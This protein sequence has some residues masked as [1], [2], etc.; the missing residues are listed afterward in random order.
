MIDTRLYTFL[1]LC[2][3]MNYRITAQA[4]HLTQP[5]VT[6]HI[7]GLEKEL[8]C[9]LFI[10]EKKKLMKTKKGELL[11]EYARYAVK[12]ELNLK[13]R[14]KACDKKKITIGAT[15]TIGNYILN[16]TIRK[17]ME[18]DEYEIEYYID[19]TKNLLYKIDH[20]ELDIAIVE[21]NFDKRKYG[22][23]NYKKEKF[24]G[25]CEKNHRIAGKEVCFEELFSY[26]LIVR[27]IG[28]GTRE[29]LEQVLREKNQSIS[30]FKKTSVCNEFERIK[31]VI[32]K[33]NGIS[34]VYEAVVKN[35]EE[36]GIFRIK[37]L[38]VERQF[39]MVYLEKNE[40]ISQKTKEILFLLEN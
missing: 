24:I 7:K 40:K 2:D 27:E 37:G 34:F 1:E 13:E 6:Q 4:L 14:L 18:M 33:G 17:L 26:P 21:G 31:D 11:E 25:I 28:S 29:V 23:T 20:G 16:E 32:R 12:Q 9:S 35:E 38:E 15:K 39:H 22:S 10:Y 30:S 8:E 5:A 3:S 19:N 36:Y